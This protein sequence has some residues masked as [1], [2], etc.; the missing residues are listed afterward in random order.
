MSAKNKEYY[1]RELVHKSW[2]RGCKET[3]ILLGH[4]AR[5]KLHEMDDDFLT[6]YATLIYESDWDIYAWLTEETKPPIQYQ[7]AVK[8]IR[9][10]H[11][12]QNAHKNQ[13]CTV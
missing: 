5:T 2:H 1:L 8:I 4:F 7:N 12:M 11:A 13:L 10:Y 9:Q 6:V 3:D